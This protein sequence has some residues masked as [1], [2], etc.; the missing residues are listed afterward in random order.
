MSYRVTLGSSS[1]SSLAALQNAANR[2]EKLQQQLS[3]GNQ[4]NRPS[5]DPS[6]SVNALTL[7]GD[8]QRNAQFARNSS[9]AVGWLTSADSAYGQIQ[10]LAQKARTLTVKG[11]NEGAST[12][13]SNMAIANEID[14]IRA[15]AIKLANTTY[16]GRPIFA[17]TSNGTEAF[18]ANGQYIGDEGTVS[19]SIGDQNTIQINQ[20]GTAAFGQNDDDNL[21]AI[22]ADISEVLNTD[23][24]GQPVGTFND[25][26][27]PLLS[28]LSVAM[29]DLVSAQAASGAALARVQSAQQTQ[30]TNN[31]TLRTHLSE[32]QDIDLAEVAIATNTAN[33]VYQAA[34][35]TTANIRQMSL[36]D[37]LR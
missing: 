28:K 26:L 11:L 33:V 5:D 6:G 21:F 25:D 34:L 9:D 20:T 27:G 22:L 32:I 35:Q 16:K 37:F 8:L 31:I 2:Y 24:S 12:G 18:N 23:Y 36:L 10:D 4:I 17:G 1:T 19:R 13:A 3:T 14:A 7:R 29:D 30:Q 15:A